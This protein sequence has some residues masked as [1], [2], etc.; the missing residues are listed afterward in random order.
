MKVVNGTLV[1]WGSDNFSV[2]PYRSWPGPPSSLEQLATRLG[3]DDE[4]LRELLRDEIQRRLRERGEAWE[5]L[6]RVLDKRV[7]A[8][9]DNPEAPP[10]HHQQRI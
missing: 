6:D 7:A 9:G 5:K 3:I 2:A 4:Q 10:V 8:S 1:L